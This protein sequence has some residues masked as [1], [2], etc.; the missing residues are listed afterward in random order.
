MHRERVSGKAWKNEGVNG[1]LLLIE[2]NC[3]GENGKIKKWIVYDGKV[4]F[5]KKNK[6]KAVKNNLM[7]I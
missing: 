7:S 2:A 4:F 5:V 6:K 1:G 3:R